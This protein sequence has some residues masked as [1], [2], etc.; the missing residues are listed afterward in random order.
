MLFS[1]YL[2]LPSKF[3]SAIQSYCSR[4]S[5][6]LLSYNRRLTLLRLDRRI[7]FGWVDWQM[8]FHS[9]GS[10][11]LPVWDIRHL[12][13]SGFREAELAT[14]TV[15]T[16]VM[17]PILDYCCVIYH[18]NLNDELDQLLSASNLKPWKI[19]TTIRQNTLTWKNWQSS[20][21]T[22]SDKSS[23]VTNLPI[24]HWLIRTFV[25]GSL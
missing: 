6:G 13:T 9:R 24:K 15:Y 20:T 3:F 19:Y 1:I 11:C 22:C 2:Y 12:K 23:F 5:V 17:C 25:T 7:S 4:L 8:C 16:T 10:V 21:L 18:P 14:A